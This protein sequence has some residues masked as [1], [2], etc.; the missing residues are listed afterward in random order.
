MKIVYC[1]QALSRAGGIE[2]VTS[3]KANYWAERGDEVHIITTDQRGAEF[4]FSLDARVQHHDLGLDYEHDNDLGRWRRL[5][6]LRAKRRIHR[7]RLEALLCTIRADVV[8]STFFQDAPILPSIQDGSKKILELHSSRYTKVLMYPREQRLM[9]LIGSMRIWYDERVARRFD[10]FVILTEEERAVWSRRL[11]NVEVIPNPLP[12]ELGECATLEHRQ[13]LA[14]GRYEYQKNFEALIRIWAHVAPQAPD[15]RLCIV[16]D[17]PLRGKLTRLVQELDLT[18][19]ITLAPSTRA[20]KG[21][22]TSS[23]IYA[24]TSH[25]EGLPMVLLEAQSVG[26]PI[27]AYACPS[28]PKD[29]VSDGLDGLLVPQGD[30]RAFARALLRLCSSLD[31]RFEMGKIAI[32]SSQKYSIR[33][34]MTLWCEMLSNIINTN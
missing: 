22:Y 13:V 8:V 24:L 33:R 1:L 29:I 31:Q 20:I 16:G 14:V 9:R 11:S 6:A 32:L 2:R 18:D 10:R 15:W 26:L 30:E 4:A 34:I 19:S 5:R 17:G 7:Q 28:G 25:Y 3:L 12:F 27:V 23:S 21:Y